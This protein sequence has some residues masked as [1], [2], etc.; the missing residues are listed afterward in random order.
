[1][2]PTLHPLLM[3]TVEKIGAGVA[4]DL[5]GFW[6]VWHLEGG[7]EGCRGLGMS[8]SA[9][10]RRIKIFRVTFG[11]HPDEFVLPGVTSDLVVSRST[12]A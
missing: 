8:R 1:M 10:Y 5:V 2:G 7:F 3:P 12:F 11:V 4:V 6:L 9:I